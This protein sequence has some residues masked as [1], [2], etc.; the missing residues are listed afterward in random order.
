MGEMAN[1]AWLTAFEKHLSELAL[2]P[3]TIVN[4]LA[5]VRAFAS[6]YA[7]QLHSGDLSSSADGDETAPFFSNGGSQLWSH[8]Q[9]LTKQVPQEEALSSRLGRVR[10]RIELSPDDIRA[11]RHYLEAVEERAPATVNRRLQ[12][13]RKFCQFAVNSGWIDTNPALEVTLLPEPEAA[14]PRTLSSEERHALLQAVQTARPRFARRDRAILE[15]LL[16]AGLRVSEVAGLLV[17][18]VDVGEKGGSC[19]VDSG[20]GFSSRQIPLNAEVCQ[21][22]REYLKT[23]PSDGQS[24]YLFLSQQGRPISTRSIQRLVTAY[25]RAAGLEDVSAYTLRHTCAADWLQQT[26]DLETV[27][28]LLGHQRPETTAKYITENV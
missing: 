13:L 15:L 21:T 26:G 2:S 25:A 11:Y 14:P 5:D 27:A 3:T 12:A 6:W 10:L 7:E 22:L 28:R 23:R 19:T 9:A 24:P 4:Y 17:D 16:C 18:R 20:N 1:G 8:T